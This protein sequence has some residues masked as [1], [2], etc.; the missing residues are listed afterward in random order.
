MAI[1][2]DNYLMMNG[3]MY[4]PKKH[5]PIHVQKCT[6]YVQIK[7]QWHTNHEIPKRINLNASSIVPTCKP[8]RE[9]KIIVN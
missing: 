6:L 7:Y 8:D 9:H 4:L 2:Y 3:Y 5:F 1:C